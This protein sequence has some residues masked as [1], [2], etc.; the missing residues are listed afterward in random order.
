MHAIN[1]PQ[2]TGR[3]YI[4]SYYKTMG[5]NPGKI[6]STVREKGCRGCN[7]IYRQAYSHFLFLYIYSISFT[8]NLK[9]KIKAN[10]YNI[11]RSRNTHIQH[12]VKP[13]KILF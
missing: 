2:D 8:E 11:D 13:V 5:E 3:L 6:K 10:N 12:R 9:Y 1:K 7:L 4:K